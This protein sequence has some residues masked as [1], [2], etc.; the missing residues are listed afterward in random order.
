M[1]YFVNVPH[2]GEKHAYKWAFIIEAPNEEEAKKRIAF[3]MTT[4]DSRHDMKCR[5]MEEDQSEYYDSLE[6][7]KVAVA[8]SMQEMIGGSY[9]TMYGKI[10][11]IPIDLPRDGQA[12][13]FPLHMMGEMGRR[14]SI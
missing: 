7:A 12:V 13:A 8:K 11:A 4:R 14:N 1:L 2:I 6:E 10:Q 9:E 5:L 3:I